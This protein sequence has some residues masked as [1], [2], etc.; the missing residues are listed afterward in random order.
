MQRTVIQNGVVV[1]VVEI[2]PE[3]AVVSKARGKELAAEEERVYAGRLEEWRG[4]AA[5]RKRQEEAAVAEIHARVAAREAIKVRADKEKDGIK[6]AGLLR[7]MLALEKDIATKGAALIALRA[8][9]M[10]EKPRL[11]RASR[12]AHP[13]GCEVGPEGGNIGDLW[14]GVAYVRPEKV[15][16]VV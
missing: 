14:D 1:N 3:T 8:R 10:P 11:V 15:I 9:E 4:V 16:E 6:A 7:E 2:G 13:E 5:E 12:W